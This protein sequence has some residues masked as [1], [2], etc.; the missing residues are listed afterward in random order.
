[1]NTENH[2]VNTFYDSDEDVSW[3]PLTIREVKRNLKSK[4]KVDPTYRRQ[5]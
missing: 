3:G 4:T 5:T 2:P 1:M